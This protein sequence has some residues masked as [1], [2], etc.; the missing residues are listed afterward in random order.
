M[1]NPINLYE[2]LKTHKGANNLSLY[3]HLS[4]LFERLMGDNDKQ[5]FN[6]LEKISSFV[7]HNTFV[8]KDPKP[9]YEVNQ[10]VEVET[11]L[12]SWLQESLEL[13]GV[14]IYFI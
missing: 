8:Y 5:T 14:T 3:E 12:T 2:I 10:I 6:N 9:D 13:F 11:E 7:K 4:H 1:S